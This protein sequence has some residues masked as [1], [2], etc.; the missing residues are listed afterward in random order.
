LGTAAGDSN[1]IDW[2]QTNQTYALDTLI[3]ADS[4]TLVDGYT[5]YVSARVTDVA[6]NRSVVS[7]GDGILIDLTPPL[8][9]SVHDGPGTD[10][11]FTSSTTSLTANWFGFSDTVS[12]I[13]LYEV[14]LGDDSV[15]TDNI[16]PWDSVGMST[17]ITIDTLTTL[18]NA[19]VYY[20]N[21]RATDLA[22]NVSQI[23]G[24]NGIT[25]D[26]G[27]PVT[28]ILNDGLAEDEDYTNSDSTLD[29]SWA[30]FL[31]TLSGIGF[32]EY[33]FFA[34][35]DD[36]TII[37]WT[38]IGLDTS[39]TVS[40]LTLDHDASYYGSVRASDNVGHVSATALS[41]G[42]L[43]DIFSPTVGIP[44]DG[45][46]ED[47]DYQGPS[48]TLAIYWT[49][50]DT[51]EISY[52]QYSV[53]TTAGDTNIVP[54]TD[55]GTATTV[56]ISDFTLTHE[57]TYYTNVRA[58]DLAGNMST[59]ESSDGITA[60]L[61]A[62]TA[63]W[64]ND[65]FG[66]DE[67]FTSSTVRL[68][69]NWDDFADTTSGIQYYEYAV[70]TTAGESDVTSGWVS[71]GTNISFFAIFTLDET[72][73]Y[74]VSVRAVDNVN[75]VS[76]M[77][78]S[79]GITTDF[80]GPQGTWAIDG[81]SSDIDRQNFTDTYSGYW[82]H[83]I[84]E[85]SGFKTHQ[86]ALFDNDNSQYVTSWEATLDST[87]VI[88]GLELIENQTYSIHVRGIDSVDN[89][90]DIL[91]S[92]G[93]LVDLSAPAVPVNLVG[94]F[95]SER[96]YL[97]WSQNQEVDLDHY[98]IY[99]GTDMNP[100][101]LLSTTADS[102]TEA[103]M[104]GFIDGTTYYLRISATDIPGNESV[105][106]ADVVGIPQPA[107]VTWVDPDTVNF[108]N[109]EDT[110]L[111]IH[112]SQPLL[113][114]GDASATSIAY[115]N[116]DITT[117]YSA[118]DT[119]LI[120]QFNEPFASL[121]SIT[122]TINNILDWSGSSTDTKEFSYTTYMLADYDKNFQID[123]YD[124]T[125]YLTGWTNG[126]FSYEL[127][128]ITGTVPH[129]I[130]TPNNVYDLRD[131][132]AFVQM[133]YWYHQTYPLA[134]ASLANVGGFLPIEQLDRSLIV[135]LPEDAVAGQVFIQYPPNSKILSTAA[136]VTTEKN[137]YLSKND[138]NTGQMLVEWADLSQDGMQT[139]SI[140]AQSLDRD[141]SNITIGYTIY[142][143]DQQIISRGMQ[144]IE[145]KAVPDEFA[146]HNNYP[147]PFNP[148]T[149]MLYDLPEAGHTRLIIYDLMGR[150]VQTLVD[151]PMAA[152]YYRQQWDGRNTMGQMVSGGIYFY[153][154]QTNGFTRT[155]KMLLLK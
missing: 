144:N 124:L 136:D 107:V 26:T 64:V 127:G 133:W 147:N 48:D 75:N 24:S 3:N 123:V 56:T 15:R 148:V 97:E 35:S 128:P 62:P 16:V 53:G 59:V 49:G 82:L 41:D 72:I 29:L 71:V 18:T 34:A 121:D 50:A 139:V 108:L 8:G 95:S 39:V 2:Y 37:E 28:G 105:F 141:N 110:Q 14:A 143:A 9:G 106:T 81:D 151:Q 91:M 22:G 88:S 109:A 93:V 1:V 6:G 120:V 114:I 58:Y 66:E 21:V 142:G 102:T 80:T 36:S 122:L 96:I 73:T 118:A 54:W 140:D 65:G 60:D 55:N 78:T 149:T 134:L 112:F 13:V 117:S 101:T 135:T 153:Q 68:E 113:D 70:G 7:S 126:D 42:I 27:P 12:S 74:Y 103:F 129:F 116:M 61:S 19:M 150:Q 119:A 94:W 52:Y 145:L 25:I 146:L 99:G 138:Q 33:A 47:Q 17:T 125:A 131:V 45:G 46:L 44:N 63:G 83:F 23:I 43:V 98:S 132:M 40:G 32:Y 104:P 38:N 100:T 85:G 137:I 89:V 152:G 155:R 30:G 20:F 57:M 90:G 86:Y 11:Q 111:S 76:D 77:V 115:A 4:L 10:I 51:R 154:I 5:Y 79:N 87:C 67:V 130:P 69:A 31:D 92:D 84:E